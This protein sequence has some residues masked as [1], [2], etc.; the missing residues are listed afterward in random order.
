MTVRNDVDEA[1]FIE[2]IRELALDVINQGGVQNLRTVTKAP[3]RG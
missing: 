3:T 2:Q 1:D